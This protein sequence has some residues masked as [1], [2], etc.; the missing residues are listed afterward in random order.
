MYNTGCPRF[1]PQAA[2]LFRPRRGPPFRGS[3]ASSRHPST[4]RTLDG[5]SD[6]AQGVDNALRRV[7]ACRSL[8]ERGGAAER[9]GHRVAWCGG[10]LPRTP[11]NPGRRAHHRRSAD[12]TL[13]QRH[14]QPR[15]AAAH[16]ARHRVVWRGRSG[17]GGHERGAGRRGPRDEPVDGPMGHAARPHDHAPHLCRRDHRDRP[18]RGP[19]PGLHGAGTHRRPLDSPGAV[20]RPHH[21]PQDG[22]LVA[23]DAAVLSGRLTAGDHLGARAGDHHPGRHP[24]G[25]GPGAPPDRGPWAP[26]CASRR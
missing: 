1:H 24:G 17:A 5:G 6:I 4:A 2:D 18:A 3:C 25:H 26:C 22:Q 20:G 12:G 8:V 19:A 9:P 10:R 15:R 7:A 11:Q 14:D 21:L 16:R 13:P 23:A